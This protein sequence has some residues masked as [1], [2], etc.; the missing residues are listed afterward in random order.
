MTNL[1]QSIELFYGSK[2]YY[3]YKLNPTLDTTSNVKYDLPSKS[4]IDSYDDNNPCNL[5]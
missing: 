5:S 1:Q 2:Y 3:G 4:W